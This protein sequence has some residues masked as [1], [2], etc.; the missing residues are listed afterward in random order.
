MRRASWT[1]SGLEVVDEPPAPLVAGWA[2]IHVEACGI[3]GTDLHAWH[4]SVSRALGTTPGHEIVGTVT[5]GPA[6]LRDVLY[7]VSPNV[8]CGQC[9]HCQSGDPHLCRRGGYGI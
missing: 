5:D 9:E 8:T 6:D 2:R 3:C 4:G 1:E 7:A